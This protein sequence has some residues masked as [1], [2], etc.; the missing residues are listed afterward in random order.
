RHSQIGSPRGHG[1]IMKT[2]SLASGVLAVVAGMHGAL[3]ADMPLKAKA[4]P[5]VVW[6]WTGFY[7]GANGGYAWRDRTVNFTG[8][9]VLTTGDVPLPAS[10]SFNVRG[11]FGGV[12]FGYNWQ[13]TRD[14]LVG[15][16]VDF[17]GSR[18]IGSGSVPVS[19]VTG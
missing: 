3:A 17:Q 14:W 11:G 5:P 4:P 19:I 10:A 2:L 18:I 8:N 15:L 7:V 1:G 16:E 6:S 9:D 13:A 12:Q